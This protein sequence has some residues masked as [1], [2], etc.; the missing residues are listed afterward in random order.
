MLSSKGGKLDLAKLGDDLWK[1]NTSAM[2]LQS[3]AGGGGGAGVSGTQSGSGSGGGRPIVEKIVK[4]TS[5]AEL[6]SERGRSFD[7]GG[8]AM[9]VVVEV[10]RARSI[11]TVQ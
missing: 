3:S 6:R 8:A 11:E 4:N 1:G 9:M 2:G 10:E 5:T 7:C